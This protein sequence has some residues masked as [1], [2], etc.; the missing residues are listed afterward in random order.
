VTSVDLGAARQQPRGRHLPAGVRADGG[1]GHGRWRTACRGSPRPAVMRFFADRAT[2]HP[3]RSPCH[4]N[5]AMRPSQ[6]PA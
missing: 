3:R 5:A 6:R 1:A 2:A 4:A